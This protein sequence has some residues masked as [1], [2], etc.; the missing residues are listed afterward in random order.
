M[1]FVN[2]DGGHELGLQQMIEVFTSNDSSNILFCT[3]LLMVLSAD[4]V[5][6]HSETSPDHAQKSC[7]FL[8]TRG[9]K[10][11]TDF[12]RDRNVDS[13]IPRKRPPKTGHG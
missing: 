13:I 7:H 8:A 2:N 3:I 6:S 11:L 10:E 12:V 4:D 9:F 1:C 5:V